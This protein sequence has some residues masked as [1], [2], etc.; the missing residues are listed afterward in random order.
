MNP[1]RQAFLVL[2]SDLTGYSCFE[3]ES[4]GLV[5]SY[6]ELVTAILGSRGREFNA[7]VE[8]IA[9]ITDEAQREAKI[10]AAL[11]PPSPHW[12]VVSGLMSLWYLGLWT[13]L[14]DSWYQ[15][16]GLP[17]PGPKDPGRTH[18][19]SS[20]AYIEQLSYRTAHAH[21]PGAKPPGFGSWSAAPA[22]E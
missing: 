10:Q 15:E 1:Q 8:S 21:P 20:L 9:Q 5:D 16:S 3:L 22:I 17:L 19:P 18:V 2:C 4:T 11:V 14:P 7:L 12:P 6:L 13:Q